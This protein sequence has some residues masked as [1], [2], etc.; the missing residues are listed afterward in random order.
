MVALRA[1]ACMCPVIVTD[2][3][4][5]ILPAYPEVPFTAPNDINGLQARMTRALRG[6]QFPAEITP[7]ASY[8]WSGAARRYS[9]LYQTALRRG[10]TS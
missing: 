1:I 8:D 6:D 5:E 2:R 4:P 3:V 10:S 7:I 9:D